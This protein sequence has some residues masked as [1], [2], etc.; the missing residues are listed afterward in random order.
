MKIS[1][2]IEVVRSTIAG[3]SSM[4]VAS[5]TAIVASLSKQYTDVI[6]TMVDTAS[7]LQQLIDRK[8]DLVFLGMM[9]VGDPDDTSKK[10]WM[11]ER[12]EAASILHTGSTQKSH[13]LEL[14]KDLAKQKML[15]D[16]IATAPFSILYR[17]QKYT[18]Q[19]DELEFPLFLKPLRGG[20][21]Q[22][23]DEY[24]VVRT[25]H[26]L[27]DKILSLHSKNDVDIMIEHY[28]EGREFSVAIIRKKGSDD[29]IAMP[30]ELIAPEDTNGERMLSS[31]VKSQNQESAIAVINPL[32]KA[33]LSAFALSVFRALGARDYGRIDIRLNAAGEP[34]FLEANLIPSLIED[35]GSF[36]KAHKLSEGVEYDEMIA[37]IA[38]LAF[39]RPL[40]VHY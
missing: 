26:Q 38:E 37:T 16:G 15:D 22:G 29:L 9:Y 17:G 4:S 40:A 35:Y 2:H 21:G 12:L 1:K 6:L 19:V 7:D 36:P 14:N 24:S 33:A 13:R 31:K 30:L 34:H 5:A 8:P 18:D 3:L 25:I 10:I 28:L 32:E 20:G 23:V 11:S 27:R 39:T